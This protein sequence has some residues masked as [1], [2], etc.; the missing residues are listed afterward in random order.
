MI[1][2]PTTGVAT[3]IG[4]QLLV[5]THDE[6]RWDVM[7]T[8]LFWLTWWIPIPL[9]VFVGA[10]ARLWHL[11]AR[12]MIQGLMRERLAR[13]RGQGSVGEKG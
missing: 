10:L 8:P 4:S 7:A 5:T 2:L 6:G 13:K 3:V 9:T 12:G 11:W 1:S